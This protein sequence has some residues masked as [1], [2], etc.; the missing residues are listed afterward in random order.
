MNWNATTHGRRSGRGGGGPP[1]VSAFGGAR[2]LLCSRYTVSF[3]AKRMAATSNRNHQI[4][5]LPNTTG[6]T[7]F[8]FATHRLIWIYRG[9]PR[10]F[11]DFRPIEIH[12]CNSSILD[13]LG[14][15][16]T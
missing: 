14:R 9:T 12:S 15:A 11:P 8:T 2:F 7:Q 6:P 16:F 5:C 1:D 13:L 3:I 4:D 10:P